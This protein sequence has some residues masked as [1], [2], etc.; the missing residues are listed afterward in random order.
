MKTCVILQPGYIPWCGFFDQMYRSDIFVIYDDISFDRHGWRNRNR[1]KTAQGIQWLTVPVLTAKQ[2]WPL[3]K[4]IMID[5]SD[6]WRRKHLRSIQQH[7]SKALYFKDYIGIFEENYSKEWKY[8]LDLDIA[9]IYVLREVL[10]ITAE[11]KFSSDLNI[12]GDKIQRLVDTC[13]KL[14][15]TQFLE[16]AAGKNYLEGFGESLFEKNGIKLVYQDYQYPTYTQL[17]GDFIPYLSIVDLLFNEGGR[18][19]E[20]LTGHA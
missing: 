2:D 12:Q 1:I 19:L 4:D 6:N 17:Y 7:Y 9:F 14:G 5:S 20:I 11:I 13:L 10:G 18:S 16:G 15:A 8:L 3:I